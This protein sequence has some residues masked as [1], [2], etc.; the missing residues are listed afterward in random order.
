MKANPGFFLG[1]SSCWG[2][3]GGVVVF[4]SVWER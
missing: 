4:G 1:G 3:S 2:T